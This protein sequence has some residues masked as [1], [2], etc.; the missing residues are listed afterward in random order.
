M[1]QTNN[2]NFAHF[3]DKLLSHVQDGRNFKFDADD[4]LGLIL[5]LEEHE[6]YIRRVVFVKTF[7]MCFCLVL[8]YKFFGLI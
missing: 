4:Y 5:S 7:F 2:P 6:T 8:V 3:V 1:I